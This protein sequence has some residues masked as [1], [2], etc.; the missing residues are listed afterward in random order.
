MEDTTK[1]P[2]DGGPAFPRL[3]SMQPSGCGVTIANVTGGMSLHAYY[4]GKALPVAAKWLED[5]SVATAAR[6]VGVEVYL[7]EEHY[8]RALAILSHRIATAMIAARRT[9]P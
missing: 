2:D 5:M 6:I 1:K 4:V 7:W 9:Q 3:D 8:P